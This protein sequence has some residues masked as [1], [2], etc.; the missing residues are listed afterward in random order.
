MATCRRDRLRAPGGRCVLGHIGCDALGA[1][2]AI[3]LACDIRIA[4]RSA[5]VS[6][7]YARVGLSGDYGIAWL[8]TRQGVVAPVVSAR[9]EDQVAELVAG[10]AVRLTRHHL[11]ELDRVSS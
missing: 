3:A 2:L 6:T 10:T 8:L 11:A 1:G 9:S 7:G 4:A 5:F